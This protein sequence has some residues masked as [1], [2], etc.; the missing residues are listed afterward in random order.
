MNV[1]PALV[2]DIAQLMNPLGAQNT[3]RSGAGSGL[4]DLVRAESAAQTTMTQISARAQ[5]MNALY[6]QVQASGD[7]AALQ[8]LRDYMATAAG[9]FDRESLDNMIQMGTAAFA[10][11][12]SQFFTTLLGNFQSLSSEFGGQSLALTMLNEAGASFADLGLGAAQ[13]FASAADRILGADVST[14]TQGTVSREN[15][16]REFIS[17]WQDFRGADLDDAQRLEQL[18]DLSTGLMEFKETLDMRRFMTEL[19]EEIQ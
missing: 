15:T 13:A 9:E 19:R 2:P 5:E 16:L 6:E 14:T 17:T 10:D 12:Q 1:D 11:D 4:D 3:T 8:G 7:S 18:R